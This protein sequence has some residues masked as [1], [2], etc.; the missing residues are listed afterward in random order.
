M[1][2]CYIGRV[3]LY[4]NE[5]ADKRR[6]PSDSVLLLEKKKLYVLFHY[7]YFP[8]LCFGDRKRYCIFFQRTWHSSRGSVYD[9]NII[10]SIMP[11]EHTQVSCNNWKHQGPAQYY[12][13][14]II[15]IIRPEERWLI[16]K[17][18]G[19]FFVH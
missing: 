5:T 2:V 16:I 19:R 8:F 13:V 15:I 4:R 18:T 6:R 17:Y 9:D 10:I 7:C 11:T 14:R 1:S 3:Y 12:I